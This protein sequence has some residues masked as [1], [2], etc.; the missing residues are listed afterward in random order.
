ML[1]LAAGAVRLQAD[2]LQAEL[3]AL[4]LAVAAL[5]K[6]A[7]G[8]SDVTLHDVECWTSDEEVSIFP[9]TFSVALDGPGRQWR[10]PACRWGLPVCG[11]AGLGPC[12]EQTKTCCWLSDI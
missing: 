1:R 4:G 2:S 10:F 5:Y 9:V 12:S 11:R 6:L 8:C 3:T 7:Q